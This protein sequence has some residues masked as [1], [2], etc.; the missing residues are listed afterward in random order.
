MA[1][2]DIE[3]CGVKESIARLPL[4][5]SSWSAFVNLFSRVGIALW[6]DANAPWALHLGVSERIIRRWR[7]GQ[8]EV[9]EGVWRELEELVSERAPTQQRLLAAIRKRIGR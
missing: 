6:G 2:G 5:G 3:R 1:R 7:N 8:N 4:C 9:P